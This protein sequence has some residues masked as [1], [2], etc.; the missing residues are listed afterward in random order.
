M[1]V[2]APAALPEPPYYAVIFSSNRVEGGEGY[3]ETAARMLELARKQPGFLGIDSTGGEGELGIT[4]S[5]W[6]DEE[7]ILA[8]RDHAEH[9]VA[10]ADGRERWYE[11][12]AVH[13][14]RVER[15]YGF[16]RPAAGS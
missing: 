4:V 11:R 15:A 9:L 8:W 14:A 1:A 3:D 12:F 13:V 7:A 6:R 2:P 10:Q 16:V 5:Y